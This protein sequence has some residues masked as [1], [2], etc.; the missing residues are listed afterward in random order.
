MGLESD[1]RKVIIIKKKKAPE[2]Q[3]VKPEE[4]E[5]RKVKQEEG[6]RIVD[7]RM[8]ANLKQVDLARKS[9]LTVATISKWEKGEDVFDKK[10]AA[11]IAKVLNI[12]FD[13]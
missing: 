11:K 10:V 7:A 2:T 13:E 5:K 9:S 8:K 4:E 6:K 3:K 1:S 12:K